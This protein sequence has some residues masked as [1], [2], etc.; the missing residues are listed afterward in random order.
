MQGK[1]HIGVKKGVDE[2]LLYFW[3]LILAA[4]LLGFNAFSHL[5]EPIGDEAAHAFQIH[6]F[7]RGK[8]EHF[9]NLTMIPT[10]HM[11]NAFIS[12]GF[13][14]S[15]FNALRM[16][17][18][19]LSAGTIPVF[20]ILTSLAYPK[21]SRLRTLQF[22]FIPFLF[23]LFFLVYTDLL[24]LLFV[25]MVVALSMEKSYKLAG[26][27]ALAAIMTRQTNVIWVVYACTFILFERNNIEVSKKFILEY[28]KDVW[29]FVLVGFCFCSF[30][31]WNGGIAVGDKEQHPVSF[32]ISN[33]YFFL[34]VSFLLYLPLCLAN[35]RK[36]YDLLM[37]HKWLFIAIGVGFFIYML[38]YEHPH[39]YNTKELSF[40]R[41]NL[42]IYYTSDVYWLRM[43]SYVGIAWMFLTYWVSCLHSVCKTKIVLLLP[44]SLLSIVP[45]PL[46]EH[47]YYI[48][49]LCLFMVFRPPVPRRYEF[50][51]L[52]IYI[53]LTAYIAYY[54][55]RMVFFL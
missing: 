40:Y 20:F 29:P 38:T 49:T 26:I 44:F 11:L 35:V 6:W 19:I 55:S 47:R 22:I 17:N 37:R 45:L 12:Q 25:L 42:F 39:K 18:L 9:Q 43:L 15:N 54:L 14:S 34:I 7:L 4:L 16:S 24:S 13:D 31:L 5:R 1:V 2:S 48:V 32:N 3:V 28:L 33:Y 23:P 36:V 27:F 50:L 21:Q 52:L 10:Y 51:M 30:V 46:I 41:H 8:F 53:G